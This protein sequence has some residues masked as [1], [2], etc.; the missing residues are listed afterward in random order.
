LI[1]KE[2]L[3]P[4]VIDVSCEDLRSH[5]RDLN[6]RPTVYEGLAI[7]NDSAKLV[8]PEVQ[9]WAYE[10]LAELGRGGHKFAGTLLAELTL[11]GYPGADAALA[12]VAVGRWAAAI[13]LLRPLAQPGAALASA[14]RG[15]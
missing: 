10:A 14:A 7:T 12:E 3:H 6:S 13:D 8:H 15:T 2:D 4:T 1:T 11:S 5:L 9:Q